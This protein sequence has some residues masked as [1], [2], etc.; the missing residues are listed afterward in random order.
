MTGTQACISHQGGKSVYLHGEDH[1]RQIADNFDSPAQALLAFERVHAAEMRPG[2]VW[3]LTAT[4]TT[5]APLVRD[6]LTQLA[7]GEAWDTALGTPV[8]DKRGT[9]ATQ[10]LSSASWKH[11]VDGRWIRWTSSGENAD[12]QF[13]AFA[14]QHHSQNQAAWTI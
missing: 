14:A 11:T 10:P 4:G 8:N 6:L 5:R 1:L 7:N 3:V 13:D 12:I 2:R 9:A